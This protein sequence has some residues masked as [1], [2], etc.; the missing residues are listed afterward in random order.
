MWRKGQSNLSD[1]KGTRIINPIIF[2]FIL[3]IFV[4]QNGIFDV[5]GFSFYL[6]T[7]FNFLISLLR[8]SKEDAFLV[9]SGTRFH[10]W[11]PLY[12]TVSVPY[13]TVLLFVEYRHWK[14]L[15]L[16]LL[17]LIMKASFIIGGG[18]PFKNL[19]IFLA[20]HSKLFWC[21]VFYLVISRLSGKELTWS[22]WINLRA[23]SWI[24]LIRLFKE[25]KQN[26]HISGQ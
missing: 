16:Y 11:G 12:V 14:F 17:F 9:F 19:Y 2:Y 24:Q 15:R 25:R 26:I 3:G 6:L 10:I 21:I 5:W 22:L 7:V 8:I 18:K 13:F 23:R 4:K 1:G 20:R